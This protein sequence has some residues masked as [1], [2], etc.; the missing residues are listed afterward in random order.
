MNTY[1]TIGLYTVVL[2][3]ACGAAALGLATLYGL[4]Q[5]QKR[6]MSAKQWE[7]TERQVKESLES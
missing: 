5:A 4:S 1:E 6:W 7:A 3:S 2:L